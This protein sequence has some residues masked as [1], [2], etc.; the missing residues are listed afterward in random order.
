[1]VIIA[2]PSDLLAQLVATSLIYA[3]VPTCQ[4]DPAELKDVEVEWHGT[5][6]SVNGHPV[7][8]LLWRALGSPD[9]SPSSTSDRLDS[10]VVATWM[11]AASFPSVRAIN[12][13]DPAAWRRG[14][15]W[16]VWKDRLDKQGVPV[17][18][19]NGTGADSLGVTSLVVCGTVVSGP[20]A[21]PVSAAAEA[22]ESSGVRLAGVTCLPNGRVCDVDP[23][24][25]ISDSLEARRAA[26]RIANYLAA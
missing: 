4:L 16:S 26:T 2:S 22:L 11:A 14:A 6:V 10:R 9:A 12:A 7:S 23:Q 20:E 24:P 5:T 1:V 19:P 3:H 21:G 25:Q 15:D 8:G 18:A 17:Q 13:Y